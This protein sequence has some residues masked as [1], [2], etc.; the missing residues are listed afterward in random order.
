M[1][2]YKSV[3]QYCR[4]CMN[5]QSHEVAKCTSSNCYWYTWRYK[6]Q[7]GSSVKAIRNYCVEECAGQ[8]AKNRYK[9]VET[10]NPRFGCALH[11][12]RMGKNPTFKKLSEEEKNR[13]IDFLRRN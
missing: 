1:T 6:K 7:S 9:Q 5:G 13:R 2:A 11:L 12:F 10:C 3:K 4:E 8:E